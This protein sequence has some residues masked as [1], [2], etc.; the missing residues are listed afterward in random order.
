[1]VGDVSSE[2]GGRPP[3]GTSSARAE[4][5]ARARPVDL[6]DTTTLTTRSIGAAR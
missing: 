5:I 4:W 3:I 2:R 6:H 1:M